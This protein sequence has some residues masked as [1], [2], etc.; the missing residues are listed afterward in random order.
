M[1]CFIPECFF[2]PC[3]RHCGIRAS[4]PRFPR[5]CSTDV[6]RVPLSP[7]AGG[8]DDGVHVQRHVGEF[9]PRPAPRCRGVLTAAPAPIHQSPPPLPSRTEPP[10]YPMESAVRSDLIIYAAGTFCKYGIFFNC[11]VPSRIYCIAF[12]EVYWAL[13]P[14]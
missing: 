10:P 9:R 11:A 13:P 2:F 4:F 3:V 14:K 6:A 1:I 7:L 12:C 8:P 5:P